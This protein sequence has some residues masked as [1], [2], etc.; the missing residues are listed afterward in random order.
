MMTG[1]EIR[2]AV[3]RGSKIVREGYKNVHDLEDE[4]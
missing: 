1:G 2:F 3:H 4:G